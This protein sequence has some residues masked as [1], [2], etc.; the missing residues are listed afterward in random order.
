MYQ[1]GNKQKIN[2][3]NQSARQGQCNANEMW[4]EGM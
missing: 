3:N 4:A 1:Q 2:N